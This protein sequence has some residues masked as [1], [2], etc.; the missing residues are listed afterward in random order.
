[1]T[2]K[3]AI[4]LDDFR[5]IARRRLPSVI[6]DAIA[7]GA[8]DEWAVRRNREAFAS[9][10][11]RPKSLA[12]VAKR[13]AA[14]RLFGQ[15]TSL[16]V[17][18]AP[19]GIGQVIRRDSELAVAR[20]ASKA[21]AIYVQSTMT[22]CPLEEVASAAGD[23]TLWFQLYLPHTRDETEAL[24]GR[25][26]HARYKA[27]VI[28]V[29]TP[30]SG[31]RERDRRNELTIP[32][33]ATAPKLIWE[34]MSRPAWSVQFVRANHP[35][36]LRKRL[37]RRS[38]PTDAQAA[39]NAVQWPVTSEDIRFVRRHW[40]GPLIVKGIMRSDECAEY[41]D[42]G[43]D[44]FVVSNHG[45]RQ[46]DNLPGTFDILAEV[47]DAVAGRATVLLDGGIRRGEDALKAIAMGASA[48][49]VGRPYLFALAAG[50]QT[51]VEEM[52][53]ILR[54]EIDRAMALLGVC[55]LDA[56]DRTFLNI[57]PR[58]SAPQTSDDKL[59]LA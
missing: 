11:F 50:G 27:L 59:W 37:V 18:L 9:V 21:G 29:D 58:P 2:I 47:V 36:S 7:G 39:I 19:T 42:L 31:G 5:R 30:T 8:G 24:L 17:L 16:P 28:T 34:A 23:G 46:L 35:F 12:D 26:A 4:N 41:L 56:L 52:I 49:L 48:V 10:S 43:V 1:M 15:E 45:G 20:A 54:V 32:V 55:S 6:F 53:E 22:P 14:T 38:S 44:G 13:S 57:A 40:D 25:V 51:G 3:R 33:K